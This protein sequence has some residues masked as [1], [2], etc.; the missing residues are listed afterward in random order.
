MAKRKRQPPVAGAAYRVLEGPPDNKR[1][2]ITYYTDPAVIR[3]LA[4]GVKVP[5][6]ERGPSKR[7]EV[8]DIVTDLPAVSIP[9]LLEGGYLEPVEDASG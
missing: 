4:A 8:G 2:G 9:W 6:D 7:A 3:R 5:V 1:Y